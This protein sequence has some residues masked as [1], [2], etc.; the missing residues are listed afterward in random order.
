MTL[1]ITSVSFE[2]RCLALAGGL[3]ETDRHGL[4]VMLDF[5]GYEN[6]DPYLVNRARLVQR[7]TTVGIS[8]VRLLV[9]LDAPLDGEAKLRKVLATVD[10]TRVVLDIST[11]PR[12]YLFT[13]CRL[14]CDLRI[15]TVIRYYK[16]LTYG[17]RLS[18]G[19]GHVQ[20]IPGFEGSAVGGG[21]SVLIMILGF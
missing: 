19:V 13:V 9:D 15:G 8:V 21:N 4:V 5:G 20:S 7:L 6:V 18:R 3:A 10:P 14:L 1:Y 11:L 16:P 17:G 2:D 12:N